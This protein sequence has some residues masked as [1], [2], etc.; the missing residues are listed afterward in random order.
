MLKPV[1]VF[2]EQVGN[3]NL[4]WMA[5]GSGTRAVKSFQLN[6]HVLSFNIKVFKGRKFT[7]HH[8][9]MARGR[10]ILKLQIVIHNSL[11]R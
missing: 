8:E 9:Q 1:M 6:K 3:L 5:W 11:K 7:L 4:S 2:I 10:G